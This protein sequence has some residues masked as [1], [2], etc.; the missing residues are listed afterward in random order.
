M[1]AELTADEFRPYNLGGRP[2]MLGMCE[3][4]RAGG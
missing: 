4:L 3:R 2:A 1:F